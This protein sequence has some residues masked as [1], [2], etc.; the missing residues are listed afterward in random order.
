[1]S[2]C[3]HVFAARLDQLDFMLVGPYAAGDE[4]TAACSS[5]GAAGVEVEDPR[6]V[7]DVD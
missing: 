5:V 4:V 7:K 2:V 1:M 6:A 3:L